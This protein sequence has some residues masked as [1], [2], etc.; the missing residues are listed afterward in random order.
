[1]VRA[2]LGWALVSLGGVLLAGCGGSSTINTVPVS[3]TV[4]NNG[5]PLEGADVIFH[6]T[7]ESGQSASG[8]TDAQGKFT[9]RTYVSPSENPEGAIP[10]DYTVTVTKVESSSA[11]MTPEQMME[12]MAAGGGPKSAPNFAAK[13]AIPEQYRDPQKSGLTAKVPEGGV[14]DLKFDLK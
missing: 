3:G 10:G 5:A 1:M 4:T 9:L 6:P 8:R 7:T 14:E 12:K 13:S 2:I 11:G